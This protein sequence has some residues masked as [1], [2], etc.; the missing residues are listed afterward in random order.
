MVFVALVHRLLSKVEQIALERRTTLT[1]LI[2]FVEQHGLE[3]LRTW[4]DA[5]AERGEL[6]F[7]HTAKWV[8]AERL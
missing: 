8:N 1:L 5:R 3:Y 4:I 2:P 7:V 6:T